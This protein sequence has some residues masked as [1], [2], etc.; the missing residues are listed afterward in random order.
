MGA[1]GPGEASAAVGK[2]GGRDAHSNWRA[3]PD[4]HRIHPQLDSLI[5]VGQQ[6]LVVNVCAQGLPTPRI[7]AFW[8]EVSN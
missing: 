5:H 6:H 2:H 3:A 7:L 4:V 8:L 1:R